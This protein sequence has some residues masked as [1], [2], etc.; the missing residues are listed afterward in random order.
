MKKLLVIGALSS[1]SLM[2]AVSPSAASDDHGDR[3]GPPSYQCGDGLV[4]HMYN[5][6]VAGNGGDD[7]EYLTYDAVECGDWAR[8]AEETGVEELDELNGVIGLCQFD[9][10]ATE[11]GDCEETPSGH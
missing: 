11:L 2:L 4:V 8:A 5:D 10:T 6:L 9:P 1:A 7:L 3:Q